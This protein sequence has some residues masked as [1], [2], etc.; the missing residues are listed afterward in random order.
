MFKVYYGDFDGKEHIGDFATEHEANKFISKYIASM[1][2]KSYYWRMWMQNEF[3][4]VDFGSHINFFFVKEV[5][6]WD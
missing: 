5:K 6:E 3:R 2:F 4:V 1:N